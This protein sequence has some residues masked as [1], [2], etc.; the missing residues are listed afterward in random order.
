MGE[1]YFLRHGETDFN[2]RALWMGNSNIPLNDK[3]RSQIRLLIPLVKR[4]GIKHIYTS[5]LLRASES[6]EIISKEAGIIKIEIVN[7]LRERSYGIFEG[8]PKSES[9]YQKLLLS[10]S[11]EPF[12]EFSMRI[13]HTIISLP[14]S[15]KSLVISHSGVFK[16]LLSNKQ[17]LTETQKNTSIRNGEILKLKLIA[18]CS[19]NLQ[20]PNHDLSKK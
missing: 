11:P 17:I 18:H 9:N 13:W 10:D 16:A 15:K 8:M 6:A 20:N 5:P 2:N 3:G 19:E 14:L 7:D 1:F 4:L 12:S